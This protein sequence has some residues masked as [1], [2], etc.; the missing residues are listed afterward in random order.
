[1][2]AT[3]QQTLGALGETLAAG[4]LKKRGYKILRRNYECVFGE[5]DIIARDREELVFVEVKS[6]G[7]LS[8]G[9]PVESVTPRKRA[10]IIKCAKFFLKRHVTQD[11]ACRFDVVSVLFLP[12]GRSVIELIRGAFEEE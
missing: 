3:S 12:D 2:G 5:V 1:M 8:M 10:Q 9:V 11:V 6:R 7:S 4:F